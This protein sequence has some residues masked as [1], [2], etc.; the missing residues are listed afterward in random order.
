MFADRALDEMDLPGEAK[1]ALRNIKAIV[2]AQYRDRFLEMAQA[3]H[4]QAAALE[5]IQSTLSI[6]VEHLEPSLKDKIPVAFNIAG[7]DE[8]D[9]ATALVIADPIGAGYTLCQADIAR[10]TGLPDPGVSVLVRAFRLRSDELLA[11]GVRRGQ[12]KALYNY[13]PRVVER[14]R[15]LVLTSSDGDVPANARSTLRRA[16]T[17]LSG[18]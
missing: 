8:P 10:A 6:L 11:V 5:R 3:L 14:L 18:G 15:H 17:I 9:L 12:G 16:K 4:R 7:D 13:H 2:D 1:D